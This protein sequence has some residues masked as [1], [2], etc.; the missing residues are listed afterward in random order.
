VVTGEDDDG[1]IIFAQHQGSALEKLDGLAMI[2]K[3]IAGKHDHI[4][5]YLQSRTQDL[6]KRVQT[7]FVA[8][9]VIGA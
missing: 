4:G 6:G 8:E 2:V 9:T 1:L 3:G 5:V 7:V